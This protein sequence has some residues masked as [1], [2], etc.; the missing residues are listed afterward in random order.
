MIRQTPGEALRAA[1]DEALHSADPADL[2]P[3]RVLYHEPPRVYR[4]Q[5]TARPGRFGG[6]AVTFLHAHRL[7]IQGV[8]KRPGRAAGDIVPF[9]AGRACPVVHPGAQSSGLA[10]TLLL[11]NL[12]VSNAAYVFGSVARRFGE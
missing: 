9:A 3:L 8:Y 7:A 12:Y 11:G 1:L 6:G 10:C 5:G 2:G 4:G